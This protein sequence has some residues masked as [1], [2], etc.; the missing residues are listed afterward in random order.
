[1]ADIKKAIGCIDEEEAIT[2]LRSLIQI[3]SVT[4]TGNEKAV[5][6]AIKNCLKESNV[7]IVTDFISDKRENLIVSY[8]NLKQHNNDEKTLIF[9]GHF[10][11]VPPGSVT[12][13]H[14]IFDGE[15]NENK[16][17]GR[18]ASDMKSGVAAMILAIECLAK[19]QVNLNG[20]LRFVG[21]V[22]EEVDCFGAKRVIKNGQIDQATAIV[23][24]EPTSNQVKI[25]HKGVLW[26][27]ISIFGKTAHGSMPSLGVNAILGMNDF[28]NELKKYTIQYDHH[29]ILGG[30]TINIGLI[31]GGVGTNVVPDLCSIYLD[32]RTV[33]GQNH[34]DIIKDIKRLLD[35]IT[36]QNSMT[37]QVEPIN[38]LACVQTAADNPFIKLAKH[39]NISLFNNHE[40]AGGVNYYTDG[41]IFRQALPQVPILIYGPGEPQTAHQPDEW[42]DL[43][44]YI[45]SIKFYIKLAVDYL[46]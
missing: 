26:L 4:N 41:S 17:F 32:I 44:K 37:Y 11:T 8:P 10:D 25:A 27:K 40:P 14:S 29:P 45:D 46:S 12:W 43:Q 22:G 36:S 20:H 13:K 38:D 5:A 16:L 2:F 31:Q 24:G 35:N 19:A 42:V 15:I 9:S 21:T 28:I 6:D 39:T 7:T 18:G 23:I 33:P 34:T 3:D 30:S 1:M